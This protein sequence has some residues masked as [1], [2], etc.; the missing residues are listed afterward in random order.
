MFRKILI[1]AE[2][3][4]VIVLWFYLSGLLRRSDFS[5][6]QQL[7]FGAAILSSTLLFF[8]LPLSTLIL[9][10]RNPGAYGL[11]NDNLG[12]HARLAV[13]A[14]AVVIPATILF[15]VIDLLGTDFKDWLGAFI[16]ALGFA[17]AGVVMLRNSL[18]FENIAETNLSLN[19]FLAHVGLLISSI[20]L[21]YLIRPISELIAQ[22]IIALVFVAF[23][24]E[25]FFR[26]YVQS[27]LNDVFSKP[28]SLSGVNFG[29]GLIL[30]A[31]IFGLFHPLTA[32]NET[33]VPWAWAIW[34]AIGG[35]IFGFLREK[36]GAIVAPALV[37][38]AII[39]PGVLFG[40]S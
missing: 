33:P 21:V 7:V 12:R 20:G 40:G 23:L 6:Q 9:T 2:I 4:L 24:E 39:L 32:I 5:D 17:A 1:I 37:H 35:L 10:R 31:V 8:V 29:A 27:R 3:S 36:S 16:L 26:G 14:I 34:T 15:L 38:G 25:V 13:R 18:S 22:I 11:T 28:Y 19:G 30:A